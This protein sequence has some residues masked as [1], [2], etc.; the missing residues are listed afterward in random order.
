MKRPLIALDLETTGIWVEKDKIIEIGMIKLTPDGK[1]SVYSKRVNP[2]MH[3]PKEVT[4]ITG[5]SDKDVKDKPYF[6]EIAGEILEFIDDAD[7]GGFNI[8][9]FD[10][11]LIERETREAG[12]FFEWYDRNIYDAQKIY[13]IHE[14]RD[15]TAAYKFYCGKDLVDAHSAEADALATL[16]ILDAQ[17]KKYGENGA[18]IEELKGMDYDVPQEYFD[19]ERKFRWWNGALYP[20]FGKYGRRHSINDITRKDRS[21]L[22]WILNEDFSEEVKEMVRDALIGKFPRSPE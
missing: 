19:K 11:P 7:I 16:D 8:E 9:R 22:N 4:L 17:V 6:K 2:G 14:R 10:L 3:I 1:K 18:S 21:Y 15:L 13:H 20:M 5:I 12:Q